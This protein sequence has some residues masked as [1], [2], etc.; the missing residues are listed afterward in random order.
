MVYNSFKMKRDNDFVKAKIIS[1]GDELLI[2]QV[3]NTNASW[4]G[5]KLTVNGIEVISTLT[6]GDGERDIVEALDACSDAE[7][8]IMTGGLGPT[9]DDI[10]KPTLC[11]YFGTE[12]TFCQDAYDNIMSIFTLRGYQMSERNR[13]QAFIPKSYIAMSKPV[14]LA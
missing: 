5:N 11:K 12:L 2:G 6:I 10:T 13:G 14:S 4:L 3:V 1:I 7:I 8:V 9:A